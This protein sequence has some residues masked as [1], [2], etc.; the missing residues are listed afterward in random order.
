[1]II[2]FRLVSDEVDH[3]K[4]EIKI[5]A[6][7]TF[8]DLRIAICVSVGYSKNE[9]S[10]FFL[11]DEGWEKDK[12][13]TLEDMGTDSDVDSYIMDECIL[14]DY[15]DDEGARLLFTFDYLNDRSF[16]LELKDIITGRIL[17]EPLCTLSLGNA[18]AQELPI[19]APTAKAP[20]KANAK[21]TSIDDFADPLY[22]EEG[23][24]PDEFD[25]EGFSEMNLED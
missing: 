9:M 1:M 8:L 18:P 10:S 2:N 7:D 25:E 4:R 23:F 16:F 15:L 5:D 21:A 3:F 11:C 24:N 19:E 6:D 12:E 13:I 22:D 17:D 14:S 20:A